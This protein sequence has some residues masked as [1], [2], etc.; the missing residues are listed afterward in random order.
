MLVGK[1][2]HVIG[3]RPGSSK[4]TAGLDRVDDASHTEQCISTHTVSNTAER[5]DLLTRW[6][7]VESQ[8]QMLPC[9]EMVA[10]PVRNGETGNGVLLV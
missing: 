10:L 1:P 3:E 2:G 9:Q 5:W 6:S 7:G 4:D 8:L